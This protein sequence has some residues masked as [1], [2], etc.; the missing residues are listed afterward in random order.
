[1]SCSCSF[2]AEREKK[3]ARHWP[4][5]E[6]TRHF[7]FE[8]FE[9]EREREEMT[10]KGFPYSLKKPSENGVIFQICTK[11][12]SRGGKRRCGMPV[13]GPSD[14][15]RCRKFR[16]RRRYKWPCDKNK[17]NFFLLSPRGGKQDPNFSLHAYDHIPL[18][19]G[20]VFIRL[21]TW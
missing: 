18:V 2:I 6:D 3:P 4:D 1:M 10:K 16:M 15:V 5:N 19:L 21:R 11:R 17:K 12:D 9:R 14:Q 20:I 7:F 8:E 13:F